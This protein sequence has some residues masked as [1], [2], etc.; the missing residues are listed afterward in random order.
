MHLSATFPTESTQSSRRPALR[1]SRLFSWRTLRLN[2]FIRNVPNGIHAKFAKTC[3][4]FFAFI[5]LAHFAF[6]CIYPHR[7]QRN[8]RKVREDLLC[9][10]R[11]YFPGAL[12]V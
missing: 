10:L 2:A 5:F 4:A 1:S 6:K 8:P 11:V 7:S 3:S 12:C 9:V